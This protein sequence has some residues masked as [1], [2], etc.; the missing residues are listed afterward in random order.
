MISQVESFYA[1]IKRDTWGRPEDT[2]AIILCFNLTQD[3][4]S[5]K[6]HNQN[7]IHFYIS[8][9]GTIEYAGSTSAEN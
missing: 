9:A 7:D 6:N 3:E 2:A 4:D 8:S 1:Q 5:P